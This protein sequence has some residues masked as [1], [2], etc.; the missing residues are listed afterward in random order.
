VQ[1]EEENIGANLKTAMFRILQE[2]LNNVAKHARATEV[3]VSLAETGDEIRLQICDNGIGMVN[4]K[5]GDFAHRFGINS[6]KERAKLSGG[7]LDIS[8]AAETGT[9]V[10]AVWPR[11][12][13]NF[14]VPR[15]IC[16]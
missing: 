16:G 5:V 14:R 15:D 12:Q 8:S 3:R 6:M 10:E 2:A 4:A 1:I 9:K 13:K 11:R 7:V